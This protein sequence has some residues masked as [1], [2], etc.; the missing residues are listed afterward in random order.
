[1]Y[2]QF[3]DPLLNK[4]YNLISFDELGN[5]D[6]EAPCYMSDSQAP[7]HD[8]WVEA[9]IIARFCDALKLPPVHLF[10]SQGRSVHGAARFASLFPEK[11]RSC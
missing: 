6:T 2:P 9:A 11:C 8:V 3:Q 7:Y 5:G 10:A 4:T 1:M